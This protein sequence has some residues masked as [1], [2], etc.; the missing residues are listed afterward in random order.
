[1]IA[2][3]FYLHDSTLLPS[4]IYVLGETTIGISSTCVGSTLNLRYQ[5][6]E[7]FDLSLVV[8]TLTALF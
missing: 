8:C 7:P 1:M 6:H 4:S 2:Q 3:Q 5:L